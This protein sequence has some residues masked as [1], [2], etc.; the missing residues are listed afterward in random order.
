MGN[1]GNSSLYGR[2]FQPKIPPPP[3]AVEDIQVYSGDSYLG[4][5][6]TLRNMPIDDGTANAHFEVPMGDW[7]SPPIVYNDWPFDP[8]RVVTLQMY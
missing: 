5:F 8:N 3:P 1:M 4:W 2:T 7:G 6:G